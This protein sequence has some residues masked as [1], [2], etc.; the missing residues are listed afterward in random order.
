L[1][2]TSLF[3]RMPAIEPIQPWT[4]V[5]SKY[6]GMKSGGSVRGVNC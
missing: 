3:I 6:G 1:R 4:I 5:R 2:S